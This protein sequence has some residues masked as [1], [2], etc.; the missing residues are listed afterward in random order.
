VVVTHE[1]QEILD[2]VLAWKLLDNIVETGQYVP[3]G[4]SIVTTIGILSTSVSFERVP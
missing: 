3:F 4:G 1:I 2:T